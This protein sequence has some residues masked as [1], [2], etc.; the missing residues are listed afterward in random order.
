MCVVKGMNG[1]KYELVV[2]LA[3]E[4]YVDVDVCIYDGILNNV[5]LFV[6]QL[7]K[8]FVRY[9]RVVLVYYGIFCV[10]I[11]EEFIIWIGLLKCGQQ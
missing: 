2:K 6:S 1:K 5:F 11:K 9:F 10:G 7:N 8:E 4:K 3:E